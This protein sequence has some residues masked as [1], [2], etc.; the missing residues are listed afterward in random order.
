MKKRFLLQI[1]L[2]TVLVFLLS[3]QIYQQSTLI[4]PIKNYDDSIKVATMIETLG[5][6]K[7]KSK[8]IAIGV[9]SACKLTGFKPEL[10]VAL[11]YTESSFKLYAI[12]SKNYKGLMQIPHSVWWEAPNILIGSYILKEK[13]NITN[14]DLPK[15][16]CLY[17]GW[18][19]HEKKGK[20]QTRIVLNLYN[21]LKG[22]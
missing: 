4:I 6:S 1:N 11:M 10:I 22:V 14:G 12:S 20:E 2:I 17:K 19:W 7:E 13:L 8:N 18:K 16:I 5:A 21:Q 9:I 3:Y 15:A